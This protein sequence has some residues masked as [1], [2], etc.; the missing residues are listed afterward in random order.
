MV[1]SRIASG[2]LGKTACD[3]HDM[4]PGGGLADVRRKQTSVG[5]RRA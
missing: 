2:G 5:S 1:V 4:I 3:A